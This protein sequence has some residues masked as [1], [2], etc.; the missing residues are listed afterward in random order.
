MSSRFALGVAMGIVALS[1][2]GG[3]CAQPTAGSALDAML[4]DDGFWASGADDF[5]EKWKGLGFRWTSA[6]KTSS[7]SVVK[8][9]SLCGQRVGET[10]V[11]F[12]D[13]KPKAIRVSLHNRGDDG[14]ITD[15]ETFNKL[16]AEWGGLLSSLT[17]AKG[18][19]RGRDARSVVRAQ[20][21]VWTR[22]GVEYILE[23]SATGGVNDFRSEFV[24][25]TV[26]P[27]E[28]KS[29]IA[30]A[31]EDKVVRPT[32]K[33]DLPKNVVRKDGD[34]FIDGIPMVDQGQKGY[35]VNA[36]A[37]RVFNY[38]G[39]PL[40]QHEVAQMA[41]TEAGRGT[42]EM[43]MVEALKTIARKFKSRLK[44]YMERDMEGWLN[45]IKDYNKAA[46][47]AKGREMRVGNMIDVGELYASADPSLLKEAFAGGSDVDHFRKEVRESV[48][49]GIPMLWALELGIFPEQGSERLQGRGG[50]MRLVIGYNLTSDE[51]LFS[52]TWGRGHELKRMK[53]KDAI[54]ATT[55]LFAILPNR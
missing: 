22:G 45:W 3:L 4:L 23:H 35:C 54:A 48:D 25:L 21:T 44:V 30:Q 51:V 39:I 53:F 55:G 49:G 32:A 38:Y 18:E 16:L 24:R 7:R 41:D 28:H 37:S 12:G 42:S 6:A 33:A 19:E 29:L 43:E 14:A 13:G 36:A 15:K 46:K 2:S 52:D 5:S 31:T 10:I 47:K 27:A 1:L 17:G 9:L 11:E 26:A 40:T 34:V 8:G 20:G 50:H